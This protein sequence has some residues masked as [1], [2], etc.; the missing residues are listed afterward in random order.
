MQIT[1][2]NVHRDIIARIC[3][4]QWRVCGEPSQAWIC[5]RV[6]GDH[7]SAH[8][9]NDLGPLDVLLAMPNWDSAARNLSEKYKNIIYI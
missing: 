8:S 4:I 6:D 1:L 9:H 5:R 7:A 3:T 2:E